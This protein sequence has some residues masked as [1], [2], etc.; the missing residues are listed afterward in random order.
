MLTQEEEIERMR[1]ERELLD[2][3]AKRT[4]VDAAPELID[5]EARDLFQDLSQRI[6][7][8]N[9]SVEDWLKHEGK[10]SKDLEEDLKKQAKQR[11][12]LRFGMAK[13]LEDQ[14]IELTPE[15]RNAAVENFLHS[16]PDE[17][18]EEARKGMT[19]GS[20]GYAELEWRTRVEKLIQEILK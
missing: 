7:Q 16:V 4:E 10:T 14:K 5:Q 13:L 1:R 19:P 6:G 20:D 15:E 8:Q 11:L 9:M 17:H 2:E 18:K 12:A 3:I